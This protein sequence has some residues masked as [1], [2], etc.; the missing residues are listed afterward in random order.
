MHEM[1]YHFALFETYQ[2]G[3]Q[4][5]LVRNTM[6]TYSKKYHLQNILLSGGTPYPGMYVNEVRHYLL[7]GKRMEPP[8]HCPQEM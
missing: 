6:C 1:Y 3:Y 5:H 8:I 7:Q 2:F 4:F